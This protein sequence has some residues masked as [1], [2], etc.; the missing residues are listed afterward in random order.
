M[1]DAAKMAGPALLDIRNLSFGYKE[2]LVLKGV[3]LTLAAGE[4]IAITG[5]SGSGKSTLLA[6]AGL[7][8]RPPPGCVWH[9]GQ[10]MGTSTPA[11]MAERRSKLRFIFQRPYLLRSLTVVENVTTGALRSSEPNAALNARAHAI[12]G[13]LGLADI[14][15]RWPEEISGGQQQRV[16]LARAVIGKPDLLFADEPTASL[17]YESAMVVVGEMRKLAEQERCGIIITTH[18][19]RISLHATRRLNLADGMFVN[20]GE[21]S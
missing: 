7:L 17:D 12:L 9:W 4:M 19:P 11:L 1:T 13:A 3:N 16:A 8:R 2:R 5:P 21:T 18:D 14:A 6:L 15:G 20:P 10:D